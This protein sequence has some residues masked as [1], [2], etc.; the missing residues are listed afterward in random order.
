[1]PPAMFLRGSARVG[2]T[3]SR[4]WSATPR[5]DRSRR[6]ASGSTTTGRPVSNELYTVVAAIPRSA[7]SR[8]LQLVDGDVGPARIVRGWSVVGEPRALPREVV[9]VEDGRPAGQDPGHH[10]GRPRVEGERAEILHHHQVGV[11]QRPGQVRLAGWRRRRR[12]PGRGGGGR[13]ARPRPPWRWRTPAGPAPRPTWPPRRPRRPGLRGGTRAGRRSGWRHGSA[14]PSGP[15]PVPRCPGAQRLPCCGVTA[16]P[17]TPAD[18]E[19]SDRPAGRSRGV[20]SSPSP[21]TGPSGAT[22]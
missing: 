13:P 18:P 8:R 9:V 10:P 1:M 7:S 19:P 17:Q 20:R 5:A 3:T 21:S 11:V 15:R 6:R 16:E 2:W 4:P 14:P 12:W 22:P